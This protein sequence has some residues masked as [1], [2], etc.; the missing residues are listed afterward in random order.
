LKD[1]RY[2]AFEEPV[3]SNPMFEAKIQSITKHKQGQTNLSD[4]DD[5]DDEEEDDDEWD[6]VDEDDE[7]GHDLDAD[8]FIDKTVHDSDEDDE[9]GGGDRKKK[10][11]EDNIVS[12][13]NGSFEELAGQKAMAASLEREK[14][15]EMNRV[16][17]ATTALPPPGCS[18]PKKIVDSDL[19]GVLSLTDKHAVRPFVVSIPTI[20]VRCFEAVWDQDINQR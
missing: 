16:F 4:H 10:K 17:N 19:Y 3:P 6:S 7:E 20:T 8:D 1:Q 2:S 13:S 12:E 14:K 9:Q 15:R 18:D 5:E 11:T